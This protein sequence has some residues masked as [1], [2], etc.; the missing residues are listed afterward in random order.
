MSTHLTGK[1]VII[2]GGSAG[3]GL[4]T[5]NAAASEGAD[6]IIVSSNQ[7]RIDKALATLPESAQGYAVDLGNEAAVRDFFQGTGSFDHL[8]FTAG[9]RLL[10]GKLEDISS[11]DVQAAFHLRFLGTWNAVKYGSKHILP[12]GSVVLTTGI[13]GARPQAGWAAGASICGAMES[14]TRALAVELAP[15]RV[16]AVSPGVVKTDLWA[17]IPVAEREA[18]YQNIGNAL[19]VR[20]VGEV[21]DIAQTYLYLM[22][23]GFSTGQVIVVDGGAVLV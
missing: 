9:D 8:V 12:G 6:V 19:P 23:E 14:L 2:L 5:A 15:I 17:D 21:A 10:L 22:R 3:I 1:R 20:R 16:N 11:S 18:I 13:A 4:A 7:E